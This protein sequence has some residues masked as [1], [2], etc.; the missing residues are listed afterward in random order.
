[1][2]MSMQL[3]SALSSRL[4]SLF[5]SFTRL[6]PAA[7]V[8]RISTPP[9][10]TQVFALCP[11]RTDSTH[12]RRP[13]QVLDR[14]RAVL[15][16]SPAS[17]NTLRLI[18][19]R[20]DHLRSLAYVVGP[21]PYRLFQSSSCFVLERHAHPLHCVLQLGKCFDRRRAAKPSSRLRS[22]SRP[23]TQLPRQSVRSVAPHAPP[24]RPR[25]LP[26]NNVSS[27]LRSRCA[28]CSVPLFFTAMPQPA[29]LRPELN[30]DGVRTCSSTIPV[31]AP[32]H[33]SHAHPARRVSH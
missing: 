3:T 28:L 26:A 30:S 18:A 11:R 23:A 21:H 1:M 20:P 22:H 10:S 17:S 15:A 4:R 25:S 12:S 29:N 14:R 19:R 16:L 6:S 5:I 24:S 2:R 8:L 7:C 32:A 9:P 13:L 27:N 33:Q 31:S